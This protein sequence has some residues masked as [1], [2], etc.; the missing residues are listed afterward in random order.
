MYRD[1]DCDRL[2]ERIITGKQ[3]ATYG[4]LRIAIARNFAGNLPVNLPL[5][6]GGR[7]CVST[8]SGLI[9]I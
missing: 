9:D 7:L 5:S 1:C 6:D 3:E 8:L 2:W 4:Q